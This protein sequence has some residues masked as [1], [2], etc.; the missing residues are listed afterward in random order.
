MRLRGHLRYHERR[1]VTSVRTIGLVACASRKREQ[2]RSA[3]GLY[4]SPLFKG[5]RDYARN[6]CDAWYVLSA[7][8]GLIEPTKL[9]APYDETLLGMKSAKRRRWAKNVFDSL[10]EVTSVEDRFIF[11][12]GKPYREFLTP[13]LVTRGH[14]LA[15]P[16]SALGIGRQVAWLL[17]IGDETQRVRDL[18]RLYALLAHLAE[19]MGGPR[20]LSECNGRN[21]WPDKGV[22]IFF[23]PSESRMTAP[24]EHR[25]V[26][27]GTHSVSSG[28][29]TTLWQ[30]L[31]THR[32]GE[33][34][35]SGNHRGS[36]FRLHIGAA[37][38]K[39]RRLER[40][41]ASWGLGQTAPRQVRDAETELEFLVSSY[42]GAMSLLWLAIEDAAGPQS[43]RAYLE[44]NLIALLAGPSGPIDLPSSGWLGQYSNHESITRSGL[45]N[46]NHTGLIYD[47]EV[48]N[49]LEQYV[50]STIGVTRRPT[51]SLAPKNWYERS[52]KQRG[53]EQLP[54][55]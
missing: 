11:L 50:N 49:V 32:G 2:P 8:H 15:A 39:S 38:I 53:S 4:D 55:L 46:I 43:D 24:F 3:E 5:A 19:K 35:G 20:R 16:L 47:P 34:S 21:V 36:I 13:L 37:L 27:V 12:A 17:K 18:D 33:A 41:F 10:V 23:E 45:W 29:R 48:L 14:D 42:I 51:R 22:Y 40:A 7:K 6:R 1:V 44:R 26:R 54:L 9:I 31:R 52:R 25:V 28:S 30:R